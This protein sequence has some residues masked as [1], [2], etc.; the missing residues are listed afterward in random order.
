MIRFYTCMALF[1]LLLGSC[2]ET[3]ET[4]LTQFIEE[5]VTAD[6]FDKEL[7]TL[8]K[9]LAENENDLSLLIKKAKL[10]KESYD[11]SCTLETAAK[12]YRLDSSNVEARD[13][14]AWTLI[15]KSTRT[16]T[17][18]E[19]AQRHFKYIIQKKPKDVAAYVNLANT[20]SLQG[21]FKKSFQY[22][23]EGLRIDKNYR[24]AYVLKGSNYRVIGD[25]NLTISSFET[26]IQVD[27]KN[28][29]TYLNV[30]DYYVEIGNP[31]ALEYY[32]TAYDL[33][34]AKKDFL[35]RAVYGIAKTQ[36]D[37]GRNQEALAGY[38]NL[39]SIDSLFYIAN[40][41]SGYIKQ[42]HQMEIDSA[43]YYYNLALAVNPDFVQGWH[44]LGLAYIDQNRKSDA[45]RAFSNVM[46]VAPEYEPTKEAIK[47]LK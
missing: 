46:R 6:T 33:K 14:Y 34:P 42:F 23:N 28:V 18:I 24:D 13:I 29:E 2:E 20:Y 8:D 1:F 4:E 45:A 25:T 19:N 7:S 12:A 47:L 9:A 26:A 39:L 5:E 40:F 16:L 27:P 17:D 15:N 35:M 41:N 31:I 32:Q 3:K 38:R 22:I 37:L 44:N 36:Q 21:D 11:F 10:C 43:V 30:A